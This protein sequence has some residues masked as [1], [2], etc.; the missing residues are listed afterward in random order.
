[1]SLNPTPSFNQYG[2]HFQ[3]LVMHALLS[4][5][6]WAE[7]MLEVFEVTYFELKYLVYLAEKYFSYAKKYKVFPTIQ[8][9]AT[10]IKDDLKQTKDAVL[11][12]QVVD[13]LVRVKSKDSYGDL[14]HAK[15]KALEFCRKQALK[16]ALERSVELMATNKYEQCAEIV[17][18]AAMVG[19]TPSVGHEFLEDYDSRFTRLSRNAVPTGLPEIDKDEILNG[20]LGKGEIGVLV[21]PTGTGKSHWL[22]FVGCEAMKRKKNVLFYSFELSETATGVRFDS[23]LCDINSSFVV[24]SKTEIMSKYEKMNLGR[25]FIKQYPPNFATVY[26]IK[27][28]IERLNVSKGFKPDLIIIDYADIMRSTRQFDSL[29]HE[30]K[31]VYEELRGLAVE[32]D[33][34]IW[35]ASQ[36]NKEGSNSDIVDLS[37]MSEAYGKAFVADVVLTL[38]R[39]STEKA[40]GA[41]RLF[42]AKNRA[43]RD[44]LLF[45]LHIDTAKSVFKIVGDENI[46]LTS[47]NEAAAKLDIKQRFN[48]LENDT[49]LSVEKVS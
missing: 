24:D 31:L 4:D 6:K 43:G 39:K 2:K 15:E 46:A 9:L 1:M 44:G 34:P 14:P 37:N 13:Y 12:D 16:Q 20:G 21:G 49:N 8:M 18:K 47:E 3:E 36:S 41:A 7:Q 33:V 27:S 22:T 40:T 35:T 48:I 42:V 26:T 19:T 32:L 25:L 10:I 30:L 23:N 28:H 45:P 17:K 11:R 38:S 29:R 5:P